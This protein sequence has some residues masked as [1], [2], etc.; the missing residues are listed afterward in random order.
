ELVF[1]PEEPR[2]VGGH[3]VD[4][5]DALLRIAGQQ[6][7]VVLVE[8]G[9]TELAQAPAQ[10][11]EEQRLL[12]V[13]EMNARGAPDQVLEEGE[14]AIA[15]L[16]R[17]AVDPLRRRGRTTGALDHRAPAPSGPPA[18]GAAP[19]RAVSAARNSSAVRR[20]STSRMGIRRRSAFAMP[21]R[22]SAWTRV[23]KEGAGSR[24]SA[25]KSITRPTPSTRIPTTVCSPSR[26][27]SAITIP[28]R[29]SMSPR[30]R[31]NLIARSR[32]GTTWPRRLMT[33]RIQEGTPGTLV[34]LSSPMISRTWRMPRAYSSVPRWK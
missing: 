34:T 23:P 9:K 21:R 19:S 14:L 26:A 1:L 6:M 3:A 13:G 33:P 32:T 11:R 25:R 18:A 16:R 8:R 29:R 24:S 12:H 2:L 30:G 31:P 27:A 7:V 20:Q 5:P 28:G 10:P 4:H 15:D 22:K 17:P